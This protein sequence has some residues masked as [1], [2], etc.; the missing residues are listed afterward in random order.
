MLF[1][2]LSY[3]RKPKYLANI[4]AIDKKQKIWNIFRLWSFIIVGILF[5]G[6][7]MSF[8]LDW[9]GYDITKNEIVNFYTSEPI[10]IIILV[11]FLWAPISEEMTFRLG[12]K[13]S[14]YRLGFN[15]G[16]VLLIILGLLDPLL[17]ES[18]SG[19]LNKLHL[20]SGIFL[21]FVY[22]VIAGG[23]GLGTGIYLKKLDQQKI[24]KFYSHHF[25]LLFYLSAII[26][27]AVHLLNYLDLGEIFYMSIL[28]VAPQFLVGL[29]LGYIR[30]IYG[31][32]WSMIAHFLHNAVLS[33]PALILA[34][35]SQD[36]ISVLGSSEIDN[37]DKI[38]SAD[39]V[40][41]FAVLITTGLIFIFIIVALTSLLKEYFLNRKK[42]A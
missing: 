5:I 6:L 23:V 34:Y 31:L 28:L 11:A 40:L 15:L 13:Y 1:D 21:V 17:G 36:T 18:I 7:I 38:S 42:Y 27:A 25:P 3:T 2:F 8:A 22:I 26:F 32:F 29:L 14:P 9:A 41:L 35:V 24:N 10:Y 39:S 16:F 37:F 19:V 30:M 12:L 20:V 33:L 4:Q